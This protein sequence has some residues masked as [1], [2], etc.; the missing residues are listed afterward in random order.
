VRR[1]PHLVQ[2][3]GVM[4]D[5]RQIVLLKHRW[6]ILVLL[7]SGWL[8]ACSLSQKTLEGVTV[9]LSWAHS[10]EFAGFYVADQKGYYQEEGL[11]V[12][13]V[14]GGPEIDPIQAVNADLAQFGVTAGD[15]IVRA[16]VAGDDLIAVSA[17]FRYSPLVVMSLMEEGLQNPWDLKG[18]TVGVIAADLDTTWDRQ[19]MA[20]LAQLDIDPTSMNFV[21]IENYHGAD[22]LKSGRI[23]AVS[24]FFSTHEAVQARLDGDDVNLIFVSDYG[25]AVYP[26]PIFTREAFIR[27]RPDLVEGFVR[28]TLKGYMYA[29][30]HPKEAA[31]LCLKYDDNL[32]RTLQQ[33]TMYAQVP[34]ID[35]GDAMLGEMDYA[36]WKSTQD[37]LLE[38]GLISSGVDLNTLHTNVFVE[39]ARQR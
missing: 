4:N 18:K 21:P 27:Q 24:G 1:G 8:V 28:A 26:N 5:R 6:G 35:T 39:R 14:P 19:F 11:I 32:D 38:Q 3:C 17:I 7:L 2:E 23:Q 33:E 30:E 15:S 22:V 37:M 20:M 34:F 16:R 29:V 36:V 13:L 10:A 9:Q 31:E 25:V 12:S